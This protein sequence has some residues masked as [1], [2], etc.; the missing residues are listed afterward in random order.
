MSRAPFD[1]N[2][3][4]LR[5]IENA[6]IGTAVGQM[7]QTNGD[8]NASIDYELIYDPSAGEALFSLDGNGTLFTN[9]PFNYEENASHL[10]EVKASI[11]GGENVVRSFEVEV[12]DVH[13]EPFDFNA[14]VLRV[15]EDAPTGSLVGSF[16]QSMGKQTTSVVYN[17]IQ[18]SNLVPPPFRLDANGSLLLTR[19]LDYE[20]NASYVIEV[21]AWTE[22]NENKIRSFMIEVLDVYEEPFDFN[23][24]VLRVSEDAPVGSLVGSFYQSM[25]EQTGSV[26]Y[27]LI[28]GSA[29]TQP[30][31]RLDANGSLS[32][33]RELDYEKNASYAIEVSA[34]TDGNENKI[35]SFM[36][37]VLDVYEEP[38]DFNATVLR[39][40]EDAPIGSLVGSFYQ[41][42]GEQT[43]SVT[44][45]LI[46]GSASTQPPFR[47]DANGSLSLTRELDYEKNASYAIEVSAWTDGNEN[48][49]RSFMVEVLDV[50]EEPFDFNATVLRVSEDAPIGSLVGSFYQSMGEQTGS[51]SYNLI[52]GSAST[53]PPFRLD[54]NGSLSLT[55]ELDYEKNA[56][57]AIEV[58]AWTDGNENKIRSFMVEVLDVYEAPFDFNATVLSV[59]ENEPIGTLVGSV[60]QSSGKLDGPVLY[61]FDYPATQN[62]PPF[63]IESNGSVV[64]NELLDFESQPSYAVTISA[65]TN[66]GEMATHDFV[67]E[68]LDVYEAPFDFNAT[69]LSVLENEPIGTLVGSVFQSSGKLDGPVLYRFDYPVTQNPPPFMIESNG[70]VVTNELLDFESQSSYAVTILATTSKGEMAT[71]DF[72]IEVLDVYE[73]PFDFN[74]TVLSVLENEPI[75]TLVGSVFQSSG[76]LDGPVLYRFDYPVT[77]NPPPFMIESNG[78]V[79]TNELLDFESQPSYAVTISAT[80]KSGEMATH[81]FVIEVVD[82]YEAPFDFNATVFRV[83]ED[84]TIGTVVG[85]VFQT[86]GKSDVSVV[87]GLEYPQT[88]NPPPFIL[89]GNGTLVSTGMLDFET[90]PSY[91]ISIRGITSGGETAIYEF[92]IEVLD[93]DELPPNNPPSDIEIEPAPLSI[94][95]NKEVGTEVGTLMAVDLDP[96]DSHTFA[97][98]NGSGDRDN[99]YFELS[100]N[101]VLTTREVLDLGSDQTLIIRA[102]VTDSRGDS[103]SKAIMIDYIHEQ[104]GEDAVLLTDGVEVIPGWK[105]AGWFGFYFADFYPWVFH[106]NLGWLFVSEKSMEGAWFHRERLGW[107]WTSPEVFPNLY[108]IEENEWVYLDNNYPFTVLFDYQRMEWFLLDVDLYVTGSSNPGKGG[109]I[110]GLGNYQRSEL[111]TLEAVPE[112]GYLFVEWRGWFKR[113]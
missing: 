51:V 79:V 104:A 10:I 15:S 88:Q 83:F 27:N 53:L 63:M 82:V 110:K 16:Y 35:R 105:R 31:F 57:Y 98:I 90:M 101:G 85:S 108:M 36:V 48:K 40:S 99:S 14:T 22:G 91:V 81:D 78:S 33:T 6:P 100:Q 55:R 72:V 32:L 3:T 102:E 34:W 87:Y 70:S 30:P 18:D 106:E 69:V 25:G 2:A 7:Y 93:V 113:N 86:S 45:N 46:S 112:S 76:K 66:K 21:S 23:A 9:Q 19:E 68:V 4:H 89:E 109:Y 65:T 24:T 111:A 50:Y 59:L 5:V 26:T 103:F 62:P 28:R 92:T 107:V 49:I 12:M 20:K 96:L 52:R 44:Y 84:A 67:I 73:A 80:T 37:E 64:T 43:G 13:E 17:L 41:S 54:A 71:H 56:S 47:L 75:G 8:E 38:F 97:I 39:V 11:N 1:F 42:M 61:R 95:G 94:K 77:Q 29:S 60:F 58:S 74:A